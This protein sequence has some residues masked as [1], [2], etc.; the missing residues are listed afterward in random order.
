MH[1]Q[2]GIEAAVKR[3]GGGR[4]AQEGVEAELKSSSVCARAV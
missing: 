3:R 2:V 1:K 4:E